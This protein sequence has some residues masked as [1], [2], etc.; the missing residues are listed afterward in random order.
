M[1]GAEHVVLQLPGLN[2]LVF[3]SD[4]GITDAVMDPVALCVPARYLGNCRGRV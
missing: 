4:D 3:V 2:R 1:L